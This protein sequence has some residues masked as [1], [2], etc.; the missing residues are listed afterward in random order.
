M[1]REIILDTTLEFS[2][3]DQQVTIFVIEAVIL[4]IV[5]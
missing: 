4:I 5:H 3:Q 1:K 2:L